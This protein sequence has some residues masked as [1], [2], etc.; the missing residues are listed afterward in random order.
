[1]RG[2]ATNGPLSRVLVAY[3]LYDVVEFAVWVAIILWAYAEGGVEL[4]GLVAV[5]QLLPAAVLAPVVVGLM[6]RLPR[7]RALTLAHGLVGG[8]TLLT[9]LALTSSA[10][11]AVVV[12]GSALATLAMALVRPLHYASLPRLAREPRELVSANAASSVAEGLAVL[13]GPVLAGIG[14][15]VSGAGLVLSCATV[16]AIAATAL[17]LRLDLG[18]GAT[19]AS[20]SQGSWRSAFSGLAVLWRDWAALLLLAVLTTRFFIGGAVDVL[21]VSFSTAVLDLDETGAGI[22]IGAIGI[23]GLVGGVVGGVVGTRRRLAPVVAGGG[24]LLGIG[25]AAVATTSSLVPT[26]IA[27]AAGGMGGAVLLIAGRT[28]LQRTVDDSALA[29]VFAIQE[30]VSLLGV[31]LGAALAPVAVQQWGP[32]DAFV[33]MGAAVAVLALAGFLLIR[34]LDARAVLRPVETA[35]LGQVGFLA[36]LP[37]YQLERLAQHSTWLDVPA[38][39][40]VVRQGDDGDRFYAIAEGEF[41][42]VVDGLARPGLLGPGEGFGELALLR[43]QPRNATVRAVTDGRVLVVGAEDFLAAVTGGVDAHTLAAE[44]SLGHDERDRRHAG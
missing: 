29:R 15:Q 24:V 36:A 19:S 18:S 42:V 28:L 12:T 17:C 4:A 40:A 32:S 14:V 8:S 37:P 7:G 26:L 22:V 2:V 16:A 44:V 6:D 27:L 43:S 9:A 30:G 34:G 39:V 5:V 31:A 10:P 20:T 1:M 35:L 38:G 33:P 25:F 23:G 13:A 11:V 21:G 3:T 41:T